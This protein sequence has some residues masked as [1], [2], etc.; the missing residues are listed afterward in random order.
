[1]SKRK[2][3]RAPLAFV[4]DRAARVHLFQKMLEFWKAHL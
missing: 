2:R 1:M 4:T 3:P